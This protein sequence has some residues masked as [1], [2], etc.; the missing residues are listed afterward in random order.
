MSVYRGV[1]LGEWLTLEKWMEPSIFE[2]TQARDEDNLCR[3]LSEE[4]K[5]LRFRKHRDSFIQKKDIFYIK[6][7]GLNAIRLPVP[8]FLFGDDDR[9][10]NPYVPCVDY[11]DRL[12]EW[13]EE[14]GL[15]VIIDLHTAPQSQNG[16]DNGGI[17]AVSKWVTKKT[18]IDRTIYVLKEIARRYGHRD[19][20][21]GIELLNEPASDVVLVR[22]QHTYEAHDKAFAKGSKAVDLET[23]FAFSEEGYRSLRPLIKK[24]AYIIFH[25]GFRLDSWK[26]FFNDVKGLENVIMDT[27]WYLDMEEWRPE[28]TNIH[29]VNRI[30]F[31]WMNKIREVQEYCPVM[32]GEWSL[33]HNMEKGLNEF[34]VKMSYRMLASAMLFAFETAFAYFYWNYRVECKDKDGWDF[35]KCVANG[36]LPSDFS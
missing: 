3:V 24:D 16:Y 35:R 23:L 12:F 33:P 15:K 14:A 13:A 25:D 36:W 4:D 27:H 5:I 7:L 11:V 17:C 6:Q 2:G 28:H 29:F 30:L 9:Y 8:H 31:T 22:N 10:C 26:Y 21:L 18:N 20:F 32:I 19:A 34:Q 1:N